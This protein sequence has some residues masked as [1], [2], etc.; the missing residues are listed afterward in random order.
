MLE[1]F[2]GVQFT[3]IIVSLTSLYF[4]IKEEKAKKAEWEKV[5][6][7]IIKLWGDLDGK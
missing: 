1:F 4:S 3:C 7:L 2:L 6:D 5:K